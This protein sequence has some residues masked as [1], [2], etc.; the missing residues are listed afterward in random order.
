MARPPEDRSTPVTYAPAP[1][2]APGTN[3]DAV[4]RATWEEFNRL[5]Q[6]LGSL[7]PAVLA[8]AMHRR[9]RRP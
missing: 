8:L 7:D 3:I 4:T 6:F 5:A 2:P 1:P 9:S